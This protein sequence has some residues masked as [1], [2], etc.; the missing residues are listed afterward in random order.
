MGVLKQE[1]LGPGDGVAVDQFV[2]R[3]GGRLFTTSGHE[4]EED[5]FKGGTIFVDSAT[6]KLFIKFQVSLGTS[7]TLIA[8]ACFE[9]E[10]TLNGVKVKN[11]HTDNGAFA[12]REFITHVHE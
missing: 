4:K 2:V 3:Q 12:A 10:A 9:R 8:K 5:R 7:E 11:Y 6:G 1:K